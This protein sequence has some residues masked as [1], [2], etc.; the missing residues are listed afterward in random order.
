VNQ[1]KVTGVR[2]EV[3][4]TR[5][6]N[7]AKPWDNIVGYRYIAEQEDSCSEVLLG[8]T[9]ARYEWAYQWGA[10]LPSRGHMTALAASF[11]FSTRENERSNLDAE[12]EFHIKW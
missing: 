7:P 1:S 12:T 4:F 11:T 6:G 5:A 9:F 2:G 3:L 10:S 8:E